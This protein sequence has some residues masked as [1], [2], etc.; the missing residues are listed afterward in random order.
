MRQQ[1]KILSP[2]QVKKL[3]PFVQDCATK[4]G[5]SA[6]CLSLFTDSYGKDVQSVVQFGLAVLLDK[7]IYLLVAEGVKIPEHV[8]KVSSGIEFYA[9]QNQ[10]SA[11]A[12]THRL[13]EQAKQKGFAA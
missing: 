4:M 3:A 6:I 10:E 12:A 5:Q 2:K 11:T 1:G 8:K 13:L 7:P 9:P